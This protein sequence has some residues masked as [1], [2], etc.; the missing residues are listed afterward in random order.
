VVAGGTWPAGKVT[1][2]GTEGRAQ[3]QPDVGMAADSDARREPEQQ[4]GV[5]RSVTVPVDRF[6]APEWGSPAGQARMVQ[7]Q[8]GLWPATRRRSACREMMAIDGTG[9]IRRLST[10]TPS[11]EFHRIGAETLRGRN[12]CDRKRR[13]RKFTVCLDCLRSCRPH[14][15]IRPSTSATI[16]RSQPCDRCRMSG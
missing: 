15:R 2:L 10:R 13:A 3:G 7:S 11:D 1:G 12:L 6:S 8:A 4:F 16:S 9:L 5:Y 14:P